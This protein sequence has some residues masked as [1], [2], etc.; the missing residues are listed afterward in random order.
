MMVEKYNTGQFRAVRRGNMSQHKTSV[1][2]GIVVII[3]GLITMLIQL[4]VFKPPEEPPLQESA[5]VPELILPGEWFTLDNGTIDHKKPIVWNFDWADCPGATEYN[6]RILGPSG[7]ISRNYEGIAD[8]EYRHVVW[9]AYITAPHCYGWG[10]KV[11][12]KVNGEWDKWS[13]TRGFDVRP[14]Q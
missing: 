1:I 13:E 9:G 6:L 5:C 11:R 7:Q 2:I 14:L 3:I 10:W 8:S 4:G 12:A